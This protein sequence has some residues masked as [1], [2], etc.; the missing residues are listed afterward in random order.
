MCPPA[1]RMV[2]VVAWAYRDGEDGDP[3]AGTEILPV[4]ALRAAV[5]RVYSKAYSGEA[6]PNEHLTE[7]ELLAQGWWL[8]EQR[9]DTCA[10]V[11]DEDYGLIAYDDGLLITSNSVRRLV[12]C[13]WPPAEDADRLASV[14]AE[15]KAEVLD[16]AKK[17]AAV[18]PERTEE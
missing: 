1:V 9:C 4:V 8:R 10:L 12:C 5:E 2:A 18:K 11:V 3:E 13:P 14:L 17:K 7:E 15:L 16:R 6:E